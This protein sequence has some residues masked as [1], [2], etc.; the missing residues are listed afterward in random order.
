MAPKGSPP[1]PDSGYSL[2]EVLVV[3]AI[4]GTLSVVGVALL[5]N[6]SGNS[7]RAMLDELE[8]AIMDAHKY[9]ATTGQDVAIVTWGT[10]DVSTTIPTLVM[11]RGAA[12]QTSAAI[13]LVANNLLLPTPVL[14]TTD[15]AKSVSVLFAPARAREFLNAGV[16]VNGSANAVW[17]A[18]A[19]QVTSS[20]KKNDDITTV[21]PF[22]ADANFI[23]ANTAANNLFQSGLNQVTISGSNKRFNNNFIIRVTSN[24]SGMAIPGG[25][26]GL[27]VVLNNGATVYK[28]YNS[29]VANGD[30]RWRKI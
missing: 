2:I 5:G 1:S 16:V 13:Q 30:G 14:P 6:R 24:S 22:N 9:A 29:G 19:M 27:L 11:A 26:M 20:G 17:W 25:A 3:L 4:I 10:W 28:Y 12:S 8:G 18:N 7:V 21:A 23:A 15:P